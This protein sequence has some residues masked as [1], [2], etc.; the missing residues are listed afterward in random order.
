MRVIFSAKA[1]WA[2]ANDADVAE[3]VWTTS[4]IAR[5]SR[6]DMEICCGCAADVLGPSDAIG[7]G[8]TG[9]AGDVGNGAMIAGAAAGAIC[10]S[11][12]FFTGWSTAMS[13]TT[14]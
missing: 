2:V 7:A 3:K 9:G 14:S 11:F 12:V 5:K 8:G 1:V 10:G 6:V 13:S 4:I